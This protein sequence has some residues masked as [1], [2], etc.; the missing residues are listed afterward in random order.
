KLSK[1]NI[2]IKRLLLLNLNLQKLIIDSTIIAPCCIHGN[3]ILSFI[4]KLFDLGILKL[5]INSKYHFNS[6]N[7]K[8]NL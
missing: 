1:K 6:K 4:K 3:E 2:R 5:M 7:I 8:M